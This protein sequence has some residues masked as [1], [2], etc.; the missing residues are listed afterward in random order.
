[1][2]RDSETV[3]QEGFLQRWSR[4]KRGQE[5]DEPATPRVNELNDKTDRHPVVEAANENV[6]LP[7][8]ESLTY[9]SDYSAFLSEKVEEAVKRKALRMLFHHPSFN[10]VDG[11]N[12]YDDDFTHFEP[13]G[14]VIVH[15]MKHLL[16]EESETLSDAQNASCDIAG[17]DLPDNE[18]ADDLQPTALSA[19]RDGAEVVTD[20]AGDLQEPEEDDESMWG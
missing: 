3:N 10:L 9:E 19:E 15:N 16:G 2:S 20:S 6:A 14:D 11:L 17:T 7:P 13:L 18:T 4:R 12:D 1:M 5:I 8:L